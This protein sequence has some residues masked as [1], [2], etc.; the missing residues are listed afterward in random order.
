MKGPCDLWLP[1]VEHTKPNVSQP[2]CDSCHIAWVTFIRALLNV[3]FHLYNLGDVLGK[4]LFLVTA[5]RCSL[6]LFQTFLEDA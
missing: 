3:V 6:N 1:L 4:V 2:P 5:I